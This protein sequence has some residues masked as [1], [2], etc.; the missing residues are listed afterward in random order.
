[1]AAALQVVFV[2]LARTKS[3]DCLAG[4]ALI[5][6]ST[7]TCVHRAHE[8]AISTIKTTTEVGGDYARTTM[9]K[10][11][12]KFLLLIITIDQMGNTSNLLNWLS[13]GEL[14]SAF[15]VLRCTANVDVDAEVRTLAAHILGTM[16]V[17]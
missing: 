13:P 4:D 2:L 9:R 7:A 16:R 14:G 17:S 12:L 8:W 11:A 5:K 1:M 3:F 15:T 10:A 6:D